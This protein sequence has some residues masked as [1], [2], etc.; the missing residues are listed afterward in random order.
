MSLN[1]VSD[2]PYIPDE[3]ERFGFVGRTEEIDRLSELLVSPGCRLLTLIG[4]G[5]IGKTRLARQISY[6]LRHD[7]PHGVGAV[8]LAPLNDPNLLLHTLVETLA[9]QTPMEDLEREVCDYLHDRQMLLYFDNFEHL[10]DAAPLLTRLLDA[11]PGLRIVVTSR[12]ALNLRHEWVREVKGLSYDD[13]ESEALQLFIERARLSGYTLTQ[14]ALETVQHICQMVEGMPLAI[15]LAA[16][17]LRSLPIETIAHEIETGLDLLKTRDRDWEDR[18]RSMRTVF[19]SSWKLLTEEQRCIMQYFSLFRGGATAEALREITGASVDTLADLVDQSMLRKG[20]NGRYQV[21][22]LLRQY[23]FEQ[24]EAGDEYEDA[25]SYFSAYFLTRFMPQLEPQIKD[26]RHLEAMRRIDADFHNVAVA[27]NYA[28]QR[29]DLNSLDAALESLHFYTE[30]RERSLEGNTMLQGA[31]ECA[32]RIVPDSRTAARFE[33]RWLR[34]KLLRMPVERVELADLLAKIDHLLAIFERSGD[35][36]E[37]AFALYLRGMVFSPFPYTTTTATIEDE[38]I[39][40]FDRATELFQQVGDDFYTAET[41][42]WSG[43]RFDSE[44]GLERLLKAL[45]IQ[46]KLGEPNSTAWILNNLAGILLNAERFEEA[47]AYLLQAE[48]VMQSVGSL[49]GL[50]S[51]GLL[52]IQLMMQRGE[53]DQVAGEVGALIARVDARYPQGMKALL[54]VRAFVKSVLYNDYAGALRDAEEAF[55]IQAEL[56]PLHSTGVWWGIATTLCSNGRFSDYRILFHSVWEANWISSCREDIWMMCEALALTHEG[57]YQ[58][59]AEILGAVELMAEQ[60]TRW[61]EG[62]QVATDMRRTLQS[63]LGQHAF[64]AA[65][66]A[67]S[68]VSPVQHIQQIAQPMTQTR[69]EAVNRQLADPLTERERQ[70]LDLIVQGNSNQEIADE[71]VIAVETVKVHAR[72]IYSKLGVS[73]RTRAIGAA[74]QLGLI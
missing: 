54:G 73:G 53:F 42:T 31:A 36:R 48:N 35:V 14:D 71:L 39:Q 19:D 49:K 37:Q 69:Q 55:G 57:Q 6:E 44:E 7:F 58:R 65:M 51:I 72:N 74:R 16:S 56:V 23:A 8:W 45:K 33:T 1:N 4:P 26:R 18:H 2:L 50:M 11:A 28:L 32:A 47:T 38:A 20:T 34:F 25:I 21:N 12:I 29:E 30:I 3:L 62:W 63:R 22:E 13:E 17:W 24:L 52:K 9:L 46:Q 15:E 10:V 67:G 60:T 27:W 64:E 70:V 43:C 66:E 61:F 5:G 59:A 40:C 68:R 41:L